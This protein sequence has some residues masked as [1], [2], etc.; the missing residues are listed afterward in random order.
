MMKEGMEIRKQREDAEMG[1]KGENDDDS[2]EDEGDENENK[3]I[4]KF[5]GE[6]IVDVPENPELAKK[7]QERWGSGSGDAPPL[8]PAT[9][10]PGQG[11]AVDAEGSIVPPLPPSSRVEE[12]EE[13]KVEVDL[14]EL[15]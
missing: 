8:P 14:C 7:R 13:P 12:L 9:G 2:D 6:R 3:N 15:D 5:S 4:N 10:E 1:E 11:F